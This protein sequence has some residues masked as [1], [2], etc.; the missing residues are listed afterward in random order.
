MQAPAYDSTHYPNETANELVLLNGEDD[1]RPD[2]FLYYSEEIKRLA[3]SM[4]YLS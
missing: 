3:Q 4:D 2:T 1:L